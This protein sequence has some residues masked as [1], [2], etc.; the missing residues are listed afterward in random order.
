MLEN[1]ER[2]KNMSDGR[3]E[4]E[5]KRTAERD[6]KSQKV[7]DRKNTPRMFTQMTNIQVKCTLVKCTYR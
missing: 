3:M 2:V 7:H 1:N 4:R 5:R 6:E